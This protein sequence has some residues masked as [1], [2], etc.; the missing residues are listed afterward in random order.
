MG[1]FCHKFISVSWEYFCQLSL[2]GII[3]IKKCLSGWSC[4]YRVKNPHYYIFAL[5]SLLLLLLLFDNYCWYSLL[6][7]WSLSTSDKPMMFFITKPCQS[8]SLS[9][10]EKFIHAKVWLYSACTLQ[11]FLTEKDVLLLFPWRPV[12]GWDLGNEEGKQMNVLLILV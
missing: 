9:V 11:L 4:P 12:K 8:D 1:T 5:D 6:L 10:K 2:G 7:I 3:T